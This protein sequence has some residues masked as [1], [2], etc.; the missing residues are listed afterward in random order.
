MLAACATA[1]AAPAVAHATAPVEALRLLNLQRAA[2][3][4]PAIAPSAGLDDGC[5]K[6]LAYIGLNG[7][8]IASGE[9]PSKAGYTPEGDRQTLESSG[10]ELLA[11]VPAWSER[12]NPWTLAPAHLYRLLDPE[13]AVAGYG[14]TGA[15]ACLRVRGGRA[16]ASAAEL[17]SV[18]GP[19]RTGV[20]PAQVSSETP[21]LPQQL[22][23]IP[24]GQATGPNILLFTRGLRGARP[25]H[26]S[27]NLGRRCMD[28]RIRPAR[29]E[30][31]N[32]PSPSR[33]SAAATA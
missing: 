3:G 26:A 17:Y 24:A 9:D 31:V 13:V 12:S 7:G 29:R 2:N 11:G 10:V 25:R 33:G 1:L 27:P 18:P 5:A 14:D 20:P 28:S 19:G 21:Y 30:R 16:P 4:I 6:H 32:G 15:I 8:V 23:D 22:V